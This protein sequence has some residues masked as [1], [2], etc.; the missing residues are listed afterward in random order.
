[1]EN[2]A[3]LYADILTDGIDTKVVE[4]YGRIEENNEQSKTPQDPEP[5]NKD[6][7]ET[8]KEYDDSEKD[9]LELHTNEAELKSDLDKSEV[10]AVPVPEKSKWEM[11]EDVPNTPTTPDSSRHD[12]KPDKSGKVT[13]EVLKR[14]ENAIFA[15]AI[16]A[17]RPI[18][19]KKI[20]TDRAKLYCGERERKNSE[21]LVVQVSTTRHPGAE[22]AK[23]VEVPL[24]KP[25][26]SVKERLGV[27]VEDL[28][29]IVKVD[30]SYD[31]NRSC[32]LSPLSKRASEMGGAYPMMERR[33]EV[34]ERRRYDDRNRSG[35]Y[36]RNYRS[37]SRRDHRDSRRDRGR[38]IRRRED[39]PPAKRD[40]RR[41]KSPTRHRSEPR[42]EKRKRSP[43]HSE[44]ID[45]KDKK[46]RRDKKQKKEKVKKHH[47]K[48][49]EEKKEVT[50]KV[51]VCF[52]FF[53]LNYYYYFNFVLLD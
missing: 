29:R 50:S 22:P 35:K 39:E 5:P 46:R 40:Q 21:E 28:D 30:R 38:D 10:L 14:A 47:K 19:I 51:C 34:E 11:E 32:S 52:C 18:E 26:L 31:R 27:K 42:R 3:D 24:E 2:K 4:N 25:R 12:Y 6:D 37:D 36:N 16:N 15:K 44:S 41:E 20:S 1:M 7:V 9:I 49:E 48:E 43:S 17:I 8:S 53:C 13:N 23:C 33:V 45:A